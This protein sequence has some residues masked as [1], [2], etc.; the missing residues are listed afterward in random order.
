MLVF[1]APIGQCITIANV[2]LG[3]V[4][5]E[6]LYF[7]AQITSFKIPLDA[8]VTSFSASVM[9]HKKMV[10]RVTSN[11]PRIEIKQ[12]WNEIKGKLNDTKKKRQFLKISLP[13]M[14]SFPT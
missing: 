4:V 7:S 5:G 8:S 9:Y 3:P 12:V 1:R 10:L 2:T 11:L 13:K 6:F 14:M